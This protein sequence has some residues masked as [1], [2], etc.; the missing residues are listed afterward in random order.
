MRKFIIAAVVAAVAIV[1]GFIPAATAN[2]AP[3]FNGWTVTGYSTTSPGL[4]VWT[5]RQFLYKPLADAYLTKVKTLEG[6]V[7]PL[8]PVSCATFVEAQIIVR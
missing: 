4:V 2:A 3:I 6:Q 5:R 7:C 1:A 8:A